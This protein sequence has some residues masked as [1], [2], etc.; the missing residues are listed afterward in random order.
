VG[1]RA[2][3]DGCGKSRLPRDSITLSHLSSSLNTIFSRTSGQTLKQK[4]ALCGTSGDH[5]AELYF[6]IVSIL[7][8]VIVCE[9]GPS[10][11]RWFKYDRDL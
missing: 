9:C 3:L 8:S 1:P 11:T 4:R 7:K 6:N 2:S 10:C 5:G